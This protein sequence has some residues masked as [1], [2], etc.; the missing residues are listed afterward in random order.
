[1]NAARAQSDEADARGDAEEAWRQTLLAEFNENLMN[2][3]F[4][5]VLAETSKAYNVGP[6]VPSGTVAHPRDPLGRGAWSAGPPANWKPEVLNGPD[7]VRRFRE[8]GG[9]DHYVGTNFDREDAVGF[10]YPDGQVRIK[11]EFLRDVLATG[12][13]GG[14]AYILHHEARH[15]DEI[16]STG[17][18]DAAQG[19]LRAY[20][21]GIR[22][23]G[24]F[25]FTVK[26]VRKL[27]SK[28]YYY[29]SLVKSGGSFSYFPDAPE[30]LDL[31][32]AFNQAQHELGSAVI[33]REEIRRRGLEAQNYRLAKEAHARLM[34][35]YQAAASGCGLTPIMT[36]GDKT[37]GFKAGESA[38]VYFTEPVTLTQAKAGML[39]TRACWAGEM[40][41][42]EGQPCADGLGAMEA[43]WADADFRHGL[44]LD[45]DAGNIDGCLRA[46]RENSDPPKD[47]KALNKR[48]SKYWRDWNVAAKRREMEAMRELR[49]G[50]EESSRRVRGDA[51]ERS[52]RV[53]DQSYDLTPARRALEEARRSRF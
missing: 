47:M 30:E 39:M 9:T 29:R 42:S 18:G 7:E 27:T 15:F 14:I 36:Q 51:E 49:R 46:I 4:A 40:D 48:V 32:A 34:A 41:Q 3:H 8:P 20:T 21:D 37:L 33:R 35:E 25:E 5:D 17:R 53:P 1:M 2:E 10:T 44:E 43:R 28:K 11:A 50:Q 13:P 52:G 38:N 31:S 24:I 26:E 16:V 45:A 6:L 22:D 23:A 19:E 12:N